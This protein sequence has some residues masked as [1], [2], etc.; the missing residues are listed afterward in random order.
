MFKQFLYRYIFFVPVICGL[1]IQC[2]KV[3]I[4]S[5]IEKKNCLGKFFQAD[6]MPNLHSAVFSSISA[7]IGIKYGLSS[8]LFS[9]VTA[10]SAIIVHDTMQ[11]KG[12][13]GKQVHVINRI[14]SSI[15]EFRDIAS[16]PTLRMLQFKP[17]DVSAGVVLGIIGTLLLL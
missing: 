5:A 15:E 4:Y 10:Y 3:I 17:F 12:E 6:G 9:L 13:K 8:L 1:F 14:V 11:F 16:G 2:V 7:G